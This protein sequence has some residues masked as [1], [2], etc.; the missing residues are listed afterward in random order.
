[1][2]EE[3]TQDP[4]SG[5][6]QQDEVAALKEQ[7][8]TL[9]NE[10]TDLAN[11]VTGINKI[12][13]RHQQR[14]DRMAADRKASTAPNPTTPGPLGAVPGYSNQAQA[15]QEA[16][17]REYQARLETYKYQVMGQLGLTDD[18]VE[19]EMEFTSA[20]A[21]LNHLNLIAVQKQLGQ[22]QSISIDD[23]NKAVAEALEAATVPGGEEGEGEALTSGMGGLIDTGGPSG[24]VVGEK[25]E[26]LEAMYG[27]AEELRRGGSLDQ[28]GYLALRAI[29][30]DDNKVVQ[31]PDTSGSDIS[32]VNV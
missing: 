17:D 19:P 16:E 13:K 23:V 2:G 9:E 6:G 3:P 29:Y 25:N 24:T 22:S 18:D 27:K 28:A 30:A 10:K 7:I 11:Q 1:M 14:A 15:V 20:D 5:S 26:K 8:L 12:A 21:I 4:D 31:S 32:D